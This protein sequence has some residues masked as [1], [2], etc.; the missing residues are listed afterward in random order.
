MA[1]RL[2]VGFGSCIFLLLSASLVVQ[3]ADDD[4]SGPS[5]VFKDAPSSGLHVVE[6]QACRC[7]DSGS[8]EC[9]KKARVADT[10]TAV[11]AVAEKTS[12]DEAT[13]STDSR[14]GED[15]GDEVPLVG[16][17]D[18]DNMGSM[19]RMLSWAIKNSDADELKERARHAADP[20]EIKRRKEVL[21]F[22]RSLDLPSDAEVMTL[23]L[24]DLRNT[25]LSVEDHAHILEELRYLVEPIDNANDLDKLGGIQQMVEMVANASNPPILRG[26]AAAVLG[27][28]ASNN[29]LVQGQV[30][31]RGTLVHLMEIVSTPGME[32]ETVSA[33]LYTVSALTRNNLASASE[34]VRAGSV[35][36]LAELMGR[37]T[38]T[39]EPGNSRLTKKV[40]SYLA[41]MVHLMGEA[42]GAAR[43]DKDV[44]GAGDAVAGSDE[45]QDAASA[46][47]SNKGILEDAILDRGLLQAVAAALLHKD[48]EI[49]EKCLLLI[50]G[51][52]TEASSTK[53]FG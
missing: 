46:A 27:T 21:D 3:C 51:L 35:G 8:Y 47:L 32:R 7:T 16:E 1:S 6:E 2:L 53:N 12:S 9:A 10:G 44:R 41:D 49:V 52:V 39:L 17:F 48:L 50:Q 34:L 33:A 37:D 25:S 43:D 28:A 30:M 36:V 13:P 14:D 11:L 4:T 18:A 40:L 26:R 23:A 22:M 45:S 20:E 38:A 42:R 29:A 15:P 19:N 31:S 24:E 5:I